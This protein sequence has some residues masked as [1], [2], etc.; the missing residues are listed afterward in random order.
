[1][2][3][4]LFC[5]SFKNKNKWRLQNHFMNKNGFSKIKN[6]NESCHSSE[7]NAWVQNAGSKNTKKEFN[8]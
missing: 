6:K 8:A 2:F 5:F 4:Y 1:M 7:G 3:F